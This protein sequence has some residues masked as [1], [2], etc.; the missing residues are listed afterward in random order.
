MIEIIQPVACFQV[1]IQQGLL[2]SVVCVKI[3]SNHERASF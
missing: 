2:T 1:E 3:I